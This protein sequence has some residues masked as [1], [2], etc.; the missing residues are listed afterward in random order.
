MFPRAL[1]SCGSRDRARWGRTPGH[2]GVP[3]TRAAAFAVI[4]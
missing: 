2:D 1:P 3:F 4:A